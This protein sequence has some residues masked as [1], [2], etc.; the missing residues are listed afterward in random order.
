MIDLSRFLRRAQ[1][2]DAGCARIRPRTIYILPTRHGVLFSLL[3]LIMLA[4]SINYANNLGFLLT[5]LLAGLGLVAML[6]TWYN[7][8]DLELM[9]GQSD[10]V[11]AG[12]P[13][14]F[15]IRLIN[16]RRRPRPGLSLKLAGFEI[17]NT[18]LDA[19]DYQ[20]I[21][22]CIPTHRRGKC[23]LP[24]LTVSTH[25][26]LGLLRA[27][28]LVQL[29]HHCLVY[30]TPARSLPINDQPQYRHSGTGD[31]GVG[32]DDF[33]G[34]R[35]YRP[36]DAPAHIHWKGLA[37]EQPLQTK[38]FGGDRA[39]R[40]WLDWAQLQG[41]SETRLSQLC[42]G[43]LDACAEQQEYGLRLPGFELAPGR[44]ETHRRRCLEALAL[45]G[46]QP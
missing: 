40:R 14:C 18:D 34:L 13:A 23:A 22:L 9:P 19:D 3:L 15:G 21:S 27:W 38:Q 46:E 29:D 43:I 16:R 45:F 31:R 1:A 8:L 6:H 36:G 30:P 24:L 28:C 10:P 20:Q 41:D 4:G 26:P 7:L 17:R 11:F 12:D 2:D 42:R 25:Y 33:A 5:F 44:G 35:P 39:E 32:A 37:R